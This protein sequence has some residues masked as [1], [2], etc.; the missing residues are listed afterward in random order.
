MTAVALDIESQALVVSTDDFATFNG[1]TVLMKIGIEVFDDEAITARDLI[2]DVAFEAE[3][4]QFDMEGYPMQ[5]FECT[6][7]AASWSINLPP[8]FLDDI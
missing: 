2:V 4:V 5:T 7:D 8:I 6:S 1:K 3:P